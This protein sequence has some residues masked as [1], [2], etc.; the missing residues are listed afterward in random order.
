MS[1]DVKSGEV[2]IKD[3][4]VFNQDAI[5]VIEE[6]P[7]FNE[8]EKKEI[9]SASENMEN[10]FFHSQVFR[11]DTEARISVLNDVK[12]PT[13]A[14]K[15]YQSLR[16]MNV[17]QCELVNLLYDYEEK[18]QDLKIVRADIMD[19]ED[20]LEVAESEAEKIRLN[21]KIKKKEIE[22]AKTSFSLKNMKRMADGRKQEIMQWDKILRELEPVLDE[23]KIPKNDPD[24]HQKVSY[25]V[26]FIKQAR[27]S[28]LA[29]VE[30]GTAEA[31]NLLGQ[32]VT[33]MKVIKE[34][35]LEAVVAQNL[36]LEDQAFSIQNRLIAP[37]ALPEES[38]IKLLQ[39]STGQTHK[40][41]FKKIEENK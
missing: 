41:Q 4:M 33:N 16:E 38:K 19:L 34:E 28:F 6:T 25:A 24:A 17:H 40:D 7:L 37:E 23:L 15:Y 27:N 35:G 26:R 1:E 14:S 31:N 2:E 21:A 3:L 32:L 18:K 20:Q 10:S 12:F 36:T 39:Q 9:I 8:A 11:T 5:A 30:M 29:N 22:L 13:P